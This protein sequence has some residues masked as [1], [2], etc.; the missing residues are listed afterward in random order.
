VFA[1]FAAAGGPALTLGLDVQIPGDF[2]PRPLPPPA[3]SVT[4][5][6]YRVDLH[7]VLEP[8]RSSELRLRVS[9]DGV[10]V[11][12]LQPYLGAYGHLVALRAGDLA[13]LHV[14]PG[15]TPGDGTTR[16]GPDISFSAEV[17]SAGTYRLFLDFRHAG[18]VHTAPF[19]VVAGTAPAPA[20]ATTPGPAPSE[21][22]T[23]GH[24]HD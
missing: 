1:D 6:G 13:Y 16:P 18:V 19:T 4:V 3:G 8:G 15:G 24:G 7:G 2:T 5:D 10:P 21:H 9:R 11:T 23:P 20:V 14:H 17:P 22:G 12:D